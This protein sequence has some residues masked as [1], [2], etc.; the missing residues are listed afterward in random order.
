MRNN[1]V[2]KP[3]EGNKTNEFLKNAPIDK[4]HVFRFSPVPEPQ[5][6]N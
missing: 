2:K 6:K 4:I 5:L 3:M 1:V